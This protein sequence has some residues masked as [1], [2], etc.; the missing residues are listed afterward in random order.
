RPRARVLVL[1][2]AS[3]QRE[4]VEGEP[5]AIV[6][7]L[8]SLERVREGDGRREEA[9]A[10]DH[11]PLQRHAS[12]R[13]ELWGPTPRRRRRF[14]LGL[15]VEV[16]LELRARRAARGHGGRHSGAAHPRLAA[17]SGGDDL[18]VVLVNAGDVAAP[19]SLRVLQQ[20]ALFGHAARP[21]QGRAVRV[22]VTG[23]A[24]DA[25][26]TIE[27]AAGV[28]GKLARAKKMRLPADGLVRAQA[29][30]RHA[31]E[32]GEHCD[33]PTGSTA[34]GALP[35]LSPFLRDPPGLRGRRAALTTLSS[36]A[37]GPLR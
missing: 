37:P 16:R 13:A 30:A 29:A 11:A 9:V 21:R 24:A 1:D 15:G 17:V 27:G 5:R 6:V 8:S 7:A 33:E 35:L 32:P 31:E 19:G 2:A 28:R 25:P 26:Q 23:P 3:A 34:P 10:E 18:A 22:S 4:S 12:S 14:R 20:G 36:H